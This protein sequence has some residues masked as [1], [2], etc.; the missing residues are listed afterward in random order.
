MAED[1]SNNRTLL[2]TMS[3]EVTPATSPLFRF[4]TRNTRL[5]GVIMAACFAA[6]AVYG[7]YAWQTGKKLA[8]AREALA[9][10]LIIRDETDRL[11]RLKS[12]VPTVPETMRK[13]AVLALAQAA[14]QGK[15]FDAAFQSWNFLAED[16]LDSLYAPAL[17]GKAEALAGQEKYA[18]ALAALEGAALPADS[19][20]ASLITSLVADIAEKTGDISTALAAC[21]KLVTG[22]AGR[23]PEEAEFWRQK[24]ASL[25]AAKP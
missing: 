24:A 2:D 16:P 21:E 3:S 8:T 18:E 6:A 5:I 15:D 14:M 10:I 17:I 22:M 19:E 7:I 12:F 11:A 9:R 1:H 25:R 23:S 13:G 20:A 4:L